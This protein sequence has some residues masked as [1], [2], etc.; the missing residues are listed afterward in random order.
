MLLRVDNTYDTGN[1]QA[2]LNIMI[3]IKFKWP[4]KYQII[5][6]KHKPLR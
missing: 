1:R 4:I 6:S 2:K 3:L 5:R